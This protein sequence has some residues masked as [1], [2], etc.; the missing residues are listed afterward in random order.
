M[1]Y[2]QSPHTPHHYA[3]PQ[4]Q[5]IMQQ[6]AHPV[7]AVGSSSSSILPWVVGI[8][9]IA[10]VLVILNKGSKIQKA[11]KQSEK[12]EKFLREQITHKDD[13]AAWAN[14]FMEKKGIKDDFEQWVESGQAAREFAQF[15]D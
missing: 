2:F 12:T 7:G 11:R 5:P 15:E 1:R 13:L 4:M 3:T 9:G 6:T 10:L 14:Y 8:G